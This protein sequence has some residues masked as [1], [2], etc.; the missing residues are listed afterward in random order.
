MKAKRTLITLITATLATACYAANPHDLNGDKRI[1][2]EE[3]EM[4]QKKRAAENGRDYDE[5]QAKYIYKDKDRNGDG[6]LTYKEF[7]SHPNDL[8]GD[9]AISYAEWEAMHRK[10]AE[11]AGRSFN[12]K[13]VKSTFPKKDTN[14]DGKLSYREL[15]KP[16]K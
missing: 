3:F 8:D 15:A 5:Q 2:W 10:R 7:G 13:W 4:M 1:N 14:G 16:L 9:K 11:R 12:E 6:L